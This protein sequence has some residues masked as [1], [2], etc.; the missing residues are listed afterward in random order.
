M[1]D[2]SQ[3]DL[4]LVPVGLAVMLGYH[5]WLLLRIR[6]RPE[7]TVIGINAINRRI[8][9]RHIMEDPAGKHAVLAVQTMRNSI[10]ASTVLASVAITLSS[11][12][13]ALMA[14]NAA[15]GLLSSSANP[16]NRLLVGAA[17]EAAL[18]AKYFA[19]LVCFLV[20]FLLNVQS[21]RYYSHTGLLVNVP[22]AAH[23]RPARAVVRYV[24][25]TL[26]R[27]FYFWSL[28]VRAYYFSCPVFLW[29]FGPIPMCA[30]CVAMV[31]GL[32][33]LDVYKEW[34]QDDDGDG[35]G[36]GDDGGEYER[37]PPA[38]ASRVMPRDVV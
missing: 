25:G 24:T 33:F 4:V 17:G 12:V 34:D 3:L 19:I 14:S 38:A 10:M 6:R 36:D 23:R 30:S 32:Y 22:L 15:H 8:W 29:L 18:T 7:T 5:L 35:D 13:A 27:G 21:I 20:A 11:L 31:G 9:V 1:M 26:N 16:G 28:G 2:S 37:K